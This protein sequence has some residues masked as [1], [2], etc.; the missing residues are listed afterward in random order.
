M[1]LQS[2][3]ASNFGCADLLQAIPTDYLIYE[4][5]EQQHVRIESDKDLIIAV[6]DQAPI[7]LIHSMALSKFGPDYELVEF[8]QGEYDYFYLD[9]Y[10]SQGEYVLVLSLKTVLD[11]NAFRQLQQ[12]KRLSRKNLVII[13][14]PM[15]EY[16]KLAPKMQKN[17]FLAS[18]GYASILHGLA[19]SK[20]TK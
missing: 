5:I 12:L 6:S 4:Y 1:L 3:V 11:A 14:F 16:S 20:L 9:C 2:A 19:L 18:S 13:K 17:F 10:E 15:S 8:K 7:S